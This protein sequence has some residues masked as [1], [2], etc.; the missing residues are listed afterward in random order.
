[1]KRL[2]LM[3]TASTRFVC[4]VGVGGGESVRWS[5]KP[6][7]RGE[8]RRRKT[9]CR[10]L[11]LVCFEQDKEAIDQQL[12]GAA[13]DRF[14]FNGVE[15]EER[16]DSLAAAFMYDPVA[17]DVYDIAGDDKLQND[18]AEPDFGGAYLHV[19]DP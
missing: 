1:M 11:N 5:E 19:A 9:N 12:P 16:A 14:F 8:C 10:P 3:T 2:A 18:S 13:M 17:R 15:E 7:L 6:K 4:G